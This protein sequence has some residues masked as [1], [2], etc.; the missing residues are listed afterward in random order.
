MSQYSPNRRSDYAVCDSC[1]E[2]LPIEATF[3]PNCGS[4]RLSRSDSRQTE[5]PYQYDIEHDHSDGTLRA[6]KRRVM[7]VNSGRDDTRYERPRYDEARYQEKRAE[8]PVPDRP[9]LT[10]PD[11]L[12]G[13]DGEEY[14]SYGYETVPMAGALA[15]VTFLGAVLLVSVIGLFVSFFPSGDSSPAAVETTSSASQQAAEDASSAA[16]AVSS[17][18][19]KE[20][21]EVHLLPEDVRNAKYEKFTVENQTFTTVM[22]SSYISEK[23]AKGSTERAFDGSPDTCWQD[24]VTGYGKGEWLLAYNSDGSAVK[25]SEV[26]VYNGYQNEQYNTNK[27]DMYLRN[28]RVSEFTLEFDD[29]STESFRLKD[30]K[31]PQT[32]TFN[33]RETCFIRFTLRD[34]YKGTKYKDTCLSEIIYK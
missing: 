13:E 24:G 16:P 34:V 2:V 7:S 27:K 19:P 15:A 28:S 18:A 31:G 1:G 17:S 11:E 3:C 32:F 23:R 29:G 21:R 25:V 9:D 10:F 22:A 14:E 5:L 12:Y 33:E 6:G 4:R 30:E 26:T 20:K 8:A